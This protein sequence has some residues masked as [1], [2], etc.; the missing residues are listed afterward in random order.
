[1]K[2]GDN[3]TLHNPKTLQALLISQETQAYAM[4]FLSFF[5][6]AFFTVFAIRPTLI[7]FFNLQKQIEEAKET[8]SKLEMKIEQLLA[9]QQVY[10][11]YQSEL[12]LLDK[13]L[14]E[15]PEF[16][17]LIQKLEEIV[18]DKEATTTA[19][20]TIDEVTL[21]DKHELLNLGTAANAEM[22][23]EVSEA[24]NEMPAESIKFSMTIGS[25]YLN[26]KAVANHLLELKRIIGLTTLEFT[27]TKDQDNVEFP[28][29]TTLEAEA[30]Y[31]PKLND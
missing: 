24:L 12:A 13:A 10:Q 7:S 18:N 29:E 21:L 6:L 8:D 3:L 25:N 28:V 9:A 5:A 31:L 11:D 19:F 1:M 17:Q 20:E 27:N 2:K 15:N 14:P 26:N 30:F 22:S 4:A 16:A 23:P